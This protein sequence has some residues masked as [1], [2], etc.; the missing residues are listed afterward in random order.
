MSGP[1]PTLEALQAA[2]GLDDALAMV[3]AHY[4]FSRHPYFLWLAGVG[5][6]EFRRTQVPF[7][8]VVEEFSR[9]LAAVL[10]HLTDPDH[11][12]AVAENVAEEHGHGNELTSHKATFLQ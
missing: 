12:R 7:R 11:R 2:P 5:R 1:A 6:D 9:S 8:F 3:E 10:A 4:D